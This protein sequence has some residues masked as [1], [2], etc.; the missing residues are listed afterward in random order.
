M[1]F[2]T[3]DTFEKL[4]PKQKEIDSDLHAEEKLKE[5]EY[6]EQ[7]WLYRSRIFLLVFVIFM[8]MIVSGT[9]I[10]HLT[11]PDSWRW[12]SVEEEKHIRDM[13]VTT[14]SGL[15]MSAITTYFFKK[16]KK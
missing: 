4:Q 3:S 15:V 6:K 10:F 12:L 16:E 8:I 13:A 1:R 2:K 14:L 9:F 7:W 5:L 11:A